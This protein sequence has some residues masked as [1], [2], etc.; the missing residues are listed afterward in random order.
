GLL[1]QPLAFAV[2]L[3]RALLVLAVFGP[4]QLGG[5]AA[6]S[7]DVLLDGGELWQVL[8]VDL[9]DQLILRMHEQRK[10]RGM[11]GKIL[12]S[13]A[14]VLPRRRQ[15]LAEL[16]I[17]GLGRVEYRHQANKIARKHAVEQKIDL[18]WGQLH[19]ALF[20]RVLDVGLRVGDLLPIE[21]DLLLAVLDVLA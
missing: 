12:A 20:Q 10:Q 17:D 19:S 5:L 21:L 9:G 6:G 16:A 15:Q 4:E 11:H 3:E 7:A 18:L 14:E 1:R 2:S 13:C 8:L